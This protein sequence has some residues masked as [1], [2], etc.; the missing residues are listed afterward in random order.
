MPDLGARFFGPCAAS[1]G[2][3]RSRL[4][5]SPMNLTARRA[6]TMAPCARIDRAA[7]QTCRKPR[8]K[9]A[10]AESIL[11]STG[12]STRR[13]QLRWGGARQATFSSTP[14]RPS[15]TDSDGF[16][17]HVLPN[18]SCMKQVRFVGLIA[19]VAVLV[20]CESTQT[21]GMGKRPRRIW[22]R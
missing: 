22:A 6:T 15:K 11:A 21:V 1:T 17:E 16:W 13:K 9:T 20:D 4:P 8:K 19:F 2:R 5:L 18:P 12:L 3:I 10:K 7:S 14:L